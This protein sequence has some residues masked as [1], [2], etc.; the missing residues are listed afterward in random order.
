M[1]F[2]PVCGTAGHIVVALKSHSIHLK[3]LLLLL[4][5]P[6]PALLD[7]QSVQ[8]VDHLIMRR[9]ISDHL[10][11]GGFS[12]N[13]L[14]FIILLSAVTLYKAG[15]IPHAAC[16]WTALDLWMIFNHWRHWEVTFY[17]VHN[18]HANPKICSPF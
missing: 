6:S 15:C 13:F 16:I 11:T 17:E 18:M 10:I 7:C 8:L 1:H 9:F 14:E 3:P 2:V 12:K 4:P 5:P